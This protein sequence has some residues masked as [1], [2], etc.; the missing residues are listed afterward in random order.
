M[1]K[2]GNLK[3][4]KN[5][6]FE[7]F[8]TQEKEIIKMKFGKYGDKIQNENKNVERIFDTFILSVDISR[9]NLK[10]QVAY[11]KGKTSQNILT[12]LQCLGKAIINLFIVKI[13]S[14]NRFV[15]ET[16]VSSKAC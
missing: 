4:V 15:R 9:T 1:F 10:L 14:I 8:I 12:C 16:L 11:L 6:I 13:S 7:T 2:V 3:R 5:D